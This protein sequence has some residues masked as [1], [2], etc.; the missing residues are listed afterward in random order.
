MVAFQSEIILFCHTA[1]CDLDHMKTTA[2]D[3]TR[4]RW[5][6]KIVQPAYLGVVA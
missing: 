1:V 3:L 6:S 5:F 4:L 2:L